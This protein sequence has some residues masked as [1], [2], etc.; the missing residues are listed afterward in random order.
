MIEVSLTQSDEL[1]IPDETP[2]F[3]RGIHLEEFAQDQVVWDVIGGFGNVFGRRLILNT[4][5]KGMLEIV[6]DK[7]GALQKQVD[8]A[9]ESALHT[10]GSGDPGGI[11]GSGPIQLG[12]NLTTKLCDGVLDGSVDVAPLGRRILLIIVILFSS[13]IG[14]REDTRITV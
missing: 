6:C 3:N 10:V 2:E 12:D 4:V 5:I 11:L 13:G 1:A 14:S 7:V 9:G 8:V